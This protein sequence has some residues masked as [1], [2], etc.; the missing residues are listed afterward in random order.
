MGLAFPAM[1][2]KATA[3][4]VRIHRDQ[5]SLPW[6]KPSPVCVGSINRIVGA[7]RSTTNVK[8]NREIGCERSMRS[9][10]GSTSNLARLLEVPNLFRFIPKLSVSPSDNG[11][12]YINNIRLDRSV[13]TRIC[14]NGD[15]ECVRRRPV[16]SL[17]RKQRRTRPG[18]KI[19]SR[20]IVRTD[21]RDRASFSRRFNEST[22]EIIEVNSRT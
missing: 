3:C 12:I 15:R 19:P 6:L 1:T 13:F 20:T 21:D 8:R 2:V 14:P 22:V 17:S 16:L 10:D 7:W 9:Q 18:K 5:V 4:Y 11:R